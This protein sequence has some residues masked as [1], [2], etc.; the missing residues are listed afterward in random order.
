MLS[1][2]KPT[3]SSAHW[4]KDFV[5]HLR[6]VHLALLA[7]AMALIVVA[8]T[9]KPYSTAVAARELR[10]IQDL[11]THWSPEFVRNLPH[12]LFGKDYPWPEVPGK[13]GHTSFAISSD[14][15]VLYA[16]VGLESVPN[17]TIY[18]AHLPT[19]FW[20]EDFRLDYLHP[21]SLSMKQ[22]PDTVSGFR[23]WWNG[24]RT[25][26]HVYFPTYVDVGDLTR[27][28]SVTAL[29]LLSSA[30][31]SKY[32]HRFIRI[33]VYLRMFA[34]PELVDYQSDLDFSLMPRQLR[35]YASAWTRTDVDIPLLASYM[36]TKPG[37]FDQSF[38]DLDDVAQ[39][40]G[41]QSFTALEESLSKIEPSDAPVFEAFGIKFPA[42]LATIGGALVL[43][44]VQLYLF[45]YLRRLYGT[46]RDDDLGW[47]VPWIGMDS[48]S[49]GKG[50]FLTT[51]SIVPVSSLVVLGGAAA[52]RFTRGYWEFS[53]ATV[54]VTSGSHWIVDVKLAA[55][56]LAVVLS[57]FIGILSWKYRPQVVASVTLPGTNHVTTAVAAGNGDTLTADP[58]GN[59]ETDQFH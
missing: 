40:Y 52:A 15:K 21:L 53:S 43:L 41:I 16:K 48:S 38:K 6:T 3:P 20:Y 39:A 4:S 10:Q 24:L 51:V 26:C 22:I 19:E 34:H 37:T 59:Q 57:G 47:D 25:T 28:D 49:L 45:V 42:D 58:N 9:T 13:E 1:N 5:E 14:V 29:D 44:S 32:R 7:T 33:D 46:L 36:G 17:P 56:A 30:E 11:R 12:G 27:Y 2:P 54:Y 31:L 18:F 23:N 35:I 50:I 8:L 55:M